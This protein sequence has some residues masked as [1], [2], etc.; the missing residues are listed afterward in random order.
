MPVFKAI[1]K[2]VKGWRLD[3]LFEK[4]DNGEITVGAAAEKVI[5]VID[6]ILQLWEQVEPL[7]KA[8]ASNEGDASADHVKDEMLN[9]K[10]M[11]QQVQTLPDVANQLKNYRFADDDKRN[12]FYHSLVSTAALMFNDSKVS[13]FEAISFLTQIAVFVK[14]EDNSN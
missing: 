6:Q 14:G 8:I 1:F 13:L 3:L 7:Y 4:S 2:W 11:L 10:V 12:D 5:G 9:L